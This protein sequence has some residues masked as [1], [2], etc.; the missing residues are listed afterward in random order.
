MQDN[1]YFLSVFALGSTVLVVFSPPE[2]IQNLSQ[3]IPAN[4]V[5]Q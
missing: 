3:Q 4:E 1:P 2:F 5:S